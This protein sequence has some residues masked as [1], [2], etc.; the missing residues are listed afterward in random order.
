MAAKKKSKG[1]AKKLVRVLS[2]DGGGIRGI[3]PG[4]I[5]V[6]LEEILQSHKKGAR[7]A[8][9]FD[10][11]AGT[12]TGGILACLYMLPDSKNKTRP[13]LTA[14]DAVDLYL[15]RG[16]EIFDISFW[17][18]L[19]TAGGTLD[20]KYDAEELEEAL[21]HYFGDLW[22]S[23][24]LRPCLITSYD[25][26][27]RRPQF[28]T[29]HDAGT[30]ARDFRVRD[31]ARATSA[32][33]TYFE[34]ARV[35]SRSGIPY[36]LIDGGV[37]ANNPTMCAYSECRSLNQGKKGRIHNP[38][39]KQ[40][41]ILSVGTGSRRTPYA[42]KEAK[43][44]GALGWIKPVID[45]MMAGSSDTVGFHLRQIYDAVS[46]PEQYLRIEPNLGDASPALDD[47]SDENLRALRDA[48][49]EAAEAHDAELRAFAKLLH[50]NR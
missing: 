21:K 15:E 29:Q 38:R 41:A 42:W 40:M 28:F 27:R 49:V 39:A 7:I 44:W 1:R 23:D 22:L 48:G 33:P 13:L 30:N 25:I 5:L 32:A 20:E 34:A 10:F 11:V 17:H 37:F 46:K 4:Q 26:K 9:Y 14:Q 18:R 2:I 8:D 31:V 24:L 3:L 50:A 19:R 36:P 12:S 45:I 47:A 16:D 43:D 35:R 6:R